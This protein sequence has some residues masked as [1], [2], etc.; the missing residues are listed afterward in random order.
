[1]IFIGDV[2]MEFERMDE[3]I[4]GES[5]PIIQVGDL[6]IGMGG[7]SYPT[8]FPQNFH[9]IRGNHDNPEKCREHDNYLG[10]YG[11]IPDW[12]LYY[13][14]G[15]WSIDNQSR[16][17]YVDWWPEE[18][19]E[20]STLFW[21]VVPEFEEKKPRIVVTHDAPSMVVKHLFGKDSGTNTSIA[22]Q[23]AFEAHQP[24]YWLFGHHHQWRYEKINGTQFVC[25]PPLGTFHL[26]LE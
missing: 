22:L 7:C 15:A 14:S 5:Q 9:F 10:D 25:L 11:F 8:I 23:Q 6:G 26:E 24:E 17:P 18:E 16:T 21:K 4:A 19:L 2:H 1:M 13:V 12:N 20:S 3:I